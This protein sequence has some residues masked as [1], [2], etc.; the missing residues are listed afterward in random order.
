MK[1]V[2]N[3]ISFSKQIITLYLGVFL[4][5]STS[6]FVIYRNHQKISK[7]K[8]KINQI[9]NIKF[10]LYELNF[11]INQKKHSK[12]SLKINAD[13][14]DLNFKKLINIDSP[15]YDLSLTDSTKKQSIILHQPDEDKRFYD[16]Y[17]SWRTFMYL[18][19]E[20]YIKN[21]I[22][23]DKERNNVL[24]DTETIPAKLT[25]S[26]QIISSKLS[27][28]RTNNLIRYKQMRTMYGLYFMLITLT[29]LVY[30]L[31]MYYYTKKII[32]KPLD[33]L[34]T[35][36]TKIKSGELKKLQTASMNNEINQIS[37]VV[38]SIITENEDATLYIKEITSRKDNYL[39]DFKTKYAKSKLF[40]SIKNMQEELDSIAKEEKERKWIIE[41][42]AIISEILNKY[43]NNFEKLPKEI[44]QHLVK[45][46]G[47][48]QGGLFTVTK[49]NNETP[50]YLELAASYAYDRNKFINKKINKGEGILGQVWIENK[51][52]YMENI[53]T[54]HMEIKSFLGH[55]TPSSILI[56]TLVDNKEFFGVIEL[57]SLK[58]LKDYERDFVSKIAESIAATLSTVE[59]NNRTHNLLKE[60]Q[61]MTIELQ[62]QKEETKQNLEQIKAS[63]DDISRREIQKDSELKAHTQQFKEEISKYKNIAY[64]NNDIIDKLQGKLINAETDNHVIRTLKGEITLLKEANEKTVSDLKETIK[65][66][67]MRL[68]KTKKRIA[69]LEENNSSKL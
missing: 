56:E 4:I 58:P 15:L 8:D 12:I 35:S 50:L 44:I 7:Q 11:K 46:T 38:N 13:S 21:D 45:Y 49:D 16:A 60:S 69:K 43:S 42:Q 61:E 39:L 68:L 33:N 6:Y 32:L 23:Y 48:L 1:Q 19:D 36:I 18:L 62:K 52:I 30:I 67:E 31:Y 2:K 17:S 22:Y 64:T 20:Y 40:I 3:T 63:Q 51:G 9:E 14:I 66:K 24:Q 25:L 59:N 29:D 65:I 28:I 27:Q 26:R 57:A 5:I 55:K 10:A 41:G 54:D 37:A 34:L 53:P 47:S